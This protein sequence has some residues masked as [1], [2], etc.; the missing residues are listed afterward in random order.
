MVKASCWGCFP[1]ATCCNGASMISA[2]N[3]IRLNNM[4]RMT[5]RAARLYWPD[6]PLLRVAHSRNA[7]GDA[8][9][10]RAADAKNHYF[11]AYNHSGRAHSHFGF[12][13]SLWTIQAPW[14]GIRSW[15]LPAIPARLYSGGSS[16]F[17]SAFSIRSDFAACRL[18]RIHGRGSRDV[19]WDQPSPRLLGALRFRARNSAHAEPYPGYVVAT[20]SRDASLAV[21]R[22]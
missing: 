2:R 10:K 13:P 14:A 5:G 22:R 16:Q 12:L 17:L 15:R 19:H 7:K 6:S 21:L 1:F 20:G 8:R 9:V 3:W 11:S 4:W 18:L